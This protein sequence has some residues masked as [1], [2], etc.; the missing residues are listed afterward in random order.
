MTLLQL[1]GFAIFIT[2]FIVLTVFIVKDVGVE[3]AITIY[4]LT[5]LVLSL[6]YIA[7]QLI[8]QEWG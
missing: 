4:G 8:T 2:M 3:G 5:A 1:L 7:A 6:V